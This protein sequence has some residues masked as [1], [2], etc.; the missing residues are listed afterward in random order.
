MILRSISEK[1]DSKVLDKIDITLV[2]NYLLEKFKKK[3][4]EEI[5][6]KS[7]ERIENMFV[8]MANRE[9]GLNKS[10]IFNLET[11]SF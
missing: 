1:I 6:R 3:Y 11:L 8:A 5:K 7:R 9:F 2:I 10:D 4:S